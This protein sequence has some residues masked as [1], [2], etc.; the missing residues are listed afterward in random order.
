MTLIDLGPPAAEPLTL[1]DLK[2]WCRIERDDEDG[3]VLSLA[4]A[5]RET[6]EALTRMILVRRAFRL[7]VDSLPADGWIEMH[8]MPLRSVTSVTAFD[9][10]GTPTLFGPAHAVIERALGIEAV[11]LS[12]DVRAVAANGVEIEMEVGYDAGGAPDGLKLAIRRI[13]S[14]SY[15]VRAAVSPEQQPALV[16]PAAEALLLPYRRVRL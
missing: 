15:E 1:A 13:V 14:A 7:V 9:A 16:P 5:A 4:R 6:I 8:R 12:P 3:I 2:T 11:R 10:A